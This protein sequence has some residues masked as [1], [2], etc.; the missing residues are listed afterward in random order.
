MLLG[1]EQSYFHVLRW[2]ILWSVGSMT[3]NRLYWYRVWKEAEIKTVDLIQKTAAVIFPITLQICTTLMWKLFHISCLNFSEFPLP[4]KPRQH[5][6]PKRGYQ[7]LWHRM[8]RCYWWSS[9]GMF[10]CFTILEIC[11][12]FLA[13]ILQILGCG[14]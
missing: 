9:E 11:R 13:H 5:F 1:R 10:I 2:I 8:I 7:I 6:F 12:I 14:P 4:W 3:M